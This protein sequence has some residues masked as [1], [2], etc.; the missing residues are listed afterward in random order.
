[1]HPAIIRVRVHVLLALGIARSLCGRHI[2]FIGHNLAVAEGTPLAETTILWTKAMIHH[3]HNQQNETK[4][5]K[6]INKSM[7]HDPNTDHEGSSTVHSW[8]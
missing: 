1:M 4:E 6:T 5:Q 2:G 3:Q 8:T 7:H